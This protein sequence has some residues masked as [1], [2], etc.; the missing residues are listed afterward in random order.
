METVG[1]NATDLSAYCRERGLFPERP[2]PSR[3]A[4]QDSN[5]SLCHMWPTN[6]SLNG[7]TPRTREINALENELRRKERSMAEMAALLVLQKSLL[8]SVR[9]TRKTVQRR[10][11]AD[12][13]RTDQHGA[14][15]WRGSGTACCRS[16]SLCPGQCHRR[17]KFRLLQ[18]PCLILRLRADLAN[19]L[20]L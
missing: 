6:R 9:R 5:T 19:A 7:S 13:D 10:S 12:G 18:D 15:C 1:L 4:A 11:P 17:G 16:R 2:S 20:W 14:C 8:H 3:Q